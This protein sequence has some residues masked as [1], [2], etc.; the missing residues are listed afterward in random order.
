MGVNHSVYLGKLFVDYTNDIRKKRHY[1]Y[2]QERDF[3]YE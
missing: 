2:T 1:I 3:I